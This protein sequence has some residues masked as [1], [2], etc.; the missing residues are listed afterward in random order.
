MTTVDDVR[1]RLSE[2]RPVGLGRDLVAAGLVR[3][4]T[5]ENG[6]VAV[7]LVPGPLPPS[8]TVDGMRPAAISRKKATAS[9]RSSPDSVRGGSAR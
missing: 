8:A 6:V 4:V 3:D 7:A 2:I 5:L 1:E 9:S